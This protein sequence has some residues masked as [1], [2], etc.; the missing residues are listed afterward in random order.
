MQKFLKRLQVKGFV[1]G[2]LVTILLSGTMLAMANQ[3]GTIRE[4]FYGVNIV[5]NGRPLQT[6][7]I[8]RPFIMDGRTF[9]PVR[10]VSEALNVPVEWD[11]ST[12]TVYVGTG[13]T[14]RP[15]FE[16]TPTASSQNITTASG[17]MSD[18][19]FNTVFRT[20]S[21]NAGQSTTGWGEFNLNGQFSSI[22]GVL[23]R[24][25]NAAGTSNIVFIGDGIEIVRFAVDGTTVAH[26]ISVD[27]SGVLVLRIEI[28][29]DMVNFGTQR[30]QVGFA[31]PMLH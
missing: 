11:G 10:V 24:L 13:T 30:S 28:L 26:D 15:L 25:N 2:V 6:E 1:T 16:T 3:G 21:F 4:L 8:D 9:L 5:V 29:Q 18:R 20:S 12:M 17:T 31:S 19:S 7:G 23:G 22:S 14:G 27:V